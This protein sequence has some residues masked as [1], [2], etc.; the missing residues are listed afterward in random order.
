MR[1][2]GIDY[3]NK[4]V[5]L[6]FGDSETGVAVPLEVVQNEGPDQL[7][8]FITERLRNEQI[9]QVV[10]GV[11]LPTAEGP[12][13]EKLEKTQQFI[14]KLQSQVSMPIHEED[15]RYSTAEALRLQREY[16]ATAEDDALA[17]ML[18]LQ[19]FLDQQ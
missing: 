10:V 4:K 19:A 12:G 3:G 13:S 7:I 6:A 15:E 9:D 14:E 16:G 11:P 17:A 2:L 18:I 8:Q 5:G 1:Y